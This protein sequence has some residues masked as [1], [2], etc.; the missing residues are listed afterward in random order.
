MI[1]SELINKV[2][3]LVYD[4]HHGQKDK[5]GVPYIFHPY[6]LAE[7]M[8]TQDEVLTALLHDVLEDTFVT[9]EQI[10]SLGVNE[11]IMRAVRLLT[12]DKEVPYLD[13][14]EKLKENSLARKVKIADLKHNSDRRRLDCDDEK[15]IARREKY[16]KAIAILEDADRLANK[17]I[18]Y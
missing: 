15:S 5:S 8:D 6:H 12:H 2:L 14:I 10:V 9:E 17:I 3:C 1:Y 7:Q 11:E 13:Y 4:A 16:A 18:D